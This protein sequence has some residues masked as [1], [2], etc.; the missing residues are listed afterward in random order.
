MNW[1]PLIGTFWNWIDMV[2]ATA[3]TALGR[4]RRVS[5]VRLVEEDNNY[6]RLE[7]PNGTKSPKVAGERICIVDGRIPDIGPVGAA[8]M[9]GSGAELVLRSNRF[10]FRPLEL[11]QRAA[12]FLEGIIRAQ[13]DRLTPWN[14]QDAVFGWTAPAQTSADR[15]SL[16]V[17][18]TPRI[19]VAPYLAALEGLGVQSAVVSAAPLNADAGAP[20]K[21]L[22]HTGQDAFGLDRLRRILTAVL[23]LAGFSAVV[24]LSLDQ[25]VGADL[26]AQQL[27]IARQISLLRTS[28]LRDGLTA[29]PSTQKLL[30]QR[31]RETP[32]SVMVLEAL[33]RI[34]PDHT[35]VTELRIEGEKLQ[36]IGVTHDA[37]SLIPLIEQ[38]HQFTRATFFAPT[39]RSAGDR[40]ERFHIEAQIKPSFGAGT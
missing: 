8:A 34:L 26:Q 32:S 9:Q 14:A 37:P 25:L 15:I 7:F 23:L 22:E 1:Q 17:C 36:I 20:I 18:A 2:A 24:A 16:T 10:L 33:S 6:F 19:L 11:P 12:E 13:I 31:K 35:F 29:K 5:I 21:V 28:L 38:S 3:A 30:E 4:F 39:T 27:D 40:G